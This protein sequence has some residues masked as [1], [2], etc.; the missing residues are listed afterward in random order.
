MTDLQTIL[1]AASRGAR[2]QCQ[3]LSGEWRNAFALDIHS[4]ELQRIH[5]DDEHLRFGPISSRLRA[6][7]ENPPENLDLAT[8]GIELI[9][10]QSSTIDY[11]C[12]LKMD[13]DTRSIFLL[14]LAE[15]LSDEG[16]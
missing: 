13:N 4:N 6:A 7:A 2:V 14:I 11:Y 15:M 5:P 3:L 1:L 8:D 9:T 10:I 16:L 12:Y